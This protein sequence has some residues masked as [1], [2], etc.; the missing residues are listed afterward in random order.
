VSGLTAAVS[1][2]TVEDVFKA[3][4]DK[5]KFEHQ[6]SS[7]GG[8]VAVTYDIA[9]HFRNDTSVQ[10]VLDLRDDGSVYLHNLKILWDKLELTIAISIPKTCVGGGCLVPN[11]AGGC[12]VQAPKVCIFGGHPDFSF[13]LAIDGYITSEVSVEGS[14]AVSHFL[15]PDRLPTDDDWDAHD[16]KRANEWRLALAAQIVH[17]DPFHIADIVGDLFKKAIQDNIDRLLS[18]L[19]QS[20]IDL[21]NM[22]LG[23]IDSVIRDLL[24]LPDDL[25][26]WLEQLLNGPVGPIDVIS[27]FVTDFFLHKAPIT[28]MEDPLPIDDPLPIQAPFHPQALNPAM[29]PIASLL[30]QVNSKELLLQ[31]ELG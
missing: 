23:G 12:A 31:G 10:P 2:K 19:P 13:P 5:F 17:V 4:V 16:H 15:N 21:V 24:N 9:F 20:A 18:G 26:Q 7:G 28:L 1:A 8:A 25:V 30:A 6:G 11:P 22:L 14:F 29:V 3:V 27:T